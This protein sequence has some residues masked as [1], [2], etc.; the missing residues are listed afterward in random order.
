MLAV[1]NIFLAGVL[2]SS[3]L[4]ALAYNTARHGYDPAKPKAP[5]ATEMPREIQGI[6]ITPQIG[7]KLNLDLQFRDENNQVVRLGDY[8][9]KG[10]PVVLS[11]VYYS[12][13]S[14]CNLHL[15]GLNDV[16]K[17]MPWTPGNEFEVISVSF[18][19][20]ENAM[21]AQ[22][23]K[24]N[25]MREL[26]K[27]EAAEG[28][29]FL[30]GAAASTQSLADQVGFK[31]RWDEEGKQWAHASAAII[32][33]PDGTISKYIHGVMFDSR[34]MRLAL[35]DAGKG[36]IGTIIDNF[37][38]FC[39]QFDPAQNKYVFYAFNIMRA[40]AGLTAVLLAAF[41]LSFWLTTRRS[42]GRGLQ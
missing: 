5:L 29:H 20:K 4:P 1:K 18:D 28:W 26:G 10:R 35:V 12:C 40:G 38:L 19:P 6:G 39:F 34:T 13:A 3:T 33:T 27:P 23:K 25:Y 15:N 2:L 31:Y 14:L 30:T 21:L 24:A 36:K 17:E 22:Q 37:I 7:S 32:V 16:F 9:K 11:L 41:L 42:M 8:F